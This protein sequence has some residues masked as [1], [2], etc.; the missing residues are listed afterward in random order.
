MKPLVR[1]EAF[2]HVQR[3]MSSILNISYPYVEV[4]TVTVIDIQV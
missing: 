2:R 1:A 3:P 4:F